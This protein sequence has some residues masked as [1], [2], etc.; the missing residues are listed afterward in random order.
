[1]LA[2]AYWQDTYNIKQLINLYDIFVICH[3]QVMYFCVSCVVSC[4]L[5][6][7]IQT[8]LSKCVYCFRKISRVDVEPS[9]RGGAKFG[10]VSLKQGVWGAAPQKL[11]SCQFCESYLRA[12]LINSSKIYNK[13][14][15]KTVLSEEEVWWVQPFRWYSLFYSVKHGN[16]T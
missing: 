11:Q 2:I 13:G 6:T 5:V 14:L 8:C 4:L 3:Q 1:M 12:N 16:Y 15:T 7:C 10:S 9:E